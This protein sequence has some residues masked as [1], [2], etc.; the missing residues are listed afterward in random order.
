MLLLLWSQLVT[1]VLKT[2]A[3]DQPDVFETSDLPESEQHLDGVG[4]VPGDGDGGGAGG[5]AGD[6]SSDA[7]EVLHLSANEAFGKF[8]GKAVDARGVDFSD[9]LRPSKNKKG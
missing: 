5:G 9:R 8:K 4:G 3:H 7:V 1:S 6:E 2:Q